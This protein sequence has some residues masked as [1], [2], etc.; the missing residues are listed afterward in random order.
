MKETTLAKSQIPKNQHYVPR[1]LMRPFAVRGAGKSEQ[2][3]VFDKHTDRSFTARLEDVLAGRYFNTVWHNDFVQDVE[4]P[5]SKL[6]DKAA[7]VLRKLVG[8][9]SWANLNGEEQVTLGFFLAIQFIRGPD[10]RARIDQ[11]VD[12]MQAKTETMARDRG[13]KVS[14]PPTSDER[15]QMIFELMRSSAAEMAKLLL[16]K[17]W[18]LFEPEQG[19]FYLGDTP[20]AM[21]NDRKM[22][23][24]GNIGLGVPGVQIYF[25]LAPDLLLALWCPSLTEELLVA[26][27]KHR[28]MLGSLTLLNVVGVV[29]LTLVEREALVD[30]RKKW[31]FTQAMVAALKARTPL[32]SDA[33]NLRF[34]NHLQVRS[35]ERYVLARNQPFDLVKEMLAHKDSYRGGMRLSF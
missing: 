12:Q 20:L 4:G 1:M 30:L 13:R 7:P 3:K 32:K 31:P 21:H 34:I 27:K 9:R 29:P 10:T 5:L 15:K 18:L 19:E 2:V 28:A 14:A 22:G 24:Y 23:P 8:E 25:P 17:T 6:E 26:E 33:E 16:N 11:M 35:A